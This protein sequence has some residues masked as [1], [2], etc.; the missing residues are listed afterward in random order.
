MGSL[1]R[2]RESYR[3]AVFA[4]VPCSRTTAGAEALA[5]ELAEVV[6]AHP[7][8]MDAKRH[9]RAVACIATCRTCWPPRWCTR[10]AAPL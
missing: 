3:D 10:K 9:D 6:G 8:L 1:K 5:R 2:M 4:L 7:L